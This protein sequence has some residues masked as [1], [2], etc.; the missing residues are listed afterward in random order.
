M[1]K[2][3]NNNK[4]NLKLKIKIKRTHKLIN[5]IYKIINKLVHPVHISNNLKSSK[6]K[7]NRAKSIILLIKYKQNMRK[8]LFNIN[9]MYHHHNN[10]NNNKN[11]Q[12][13]N[14]TIEIK[15]S[16]SHRRRIPLQNRIPLLIKV[17]PYFWIPRS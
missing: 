5:K 15:I 10:K 16:P 8:S 6:I 13:H 1:L 11:R 17:N 12:L 9:N 4:I 3:N 14:K 7:Y 2:N